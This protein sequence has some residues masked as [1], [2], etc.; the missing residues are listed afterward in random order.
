MT[1]SIER[2]DASSTLPDLQNHAIQTP[3][4]VNIRTLVE[5]WMDENLKPICGQGKN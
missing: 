2:W 5:L 3:K 1:G 4:A